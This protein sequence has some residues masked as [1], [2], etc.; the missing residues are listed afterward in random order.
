M[1]GRLNERPHG[2]RQLAPLYLA[3]YLFWVVSGALTVLTM[4]QMRNA[5]LSLL[6]VLGPWTM[7]GVDKFS[8]V[9]MGLAALVWVLF[10]EHYLRT[11]VERGTLW[12]RALVVGGVHAA[13]LGFVYALQLLFFALW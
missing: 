5:L 4:L 11:G 6:P 8:F 12:R 7:I 10:V 9:L 2:L 13:A 1:E 3:C